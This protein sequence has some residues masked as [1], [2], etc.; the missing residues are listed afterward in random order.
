MKE[1]M[2]AAE[3]VAAKLFEKKHTIAV[4]ESSAGGLMSVARARH[5]PIRTALSGPAAG[6]VGAI[7]MA[8]LSGV[9]DVISL[10]M[11]GTSTDV[12]LIADGEAARFTERAVAGLPIRLD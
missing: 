1:L 7:H 9:P 5:V 3:K 11:G 8:K 2:A 6:A 12:C 4:A 10:D